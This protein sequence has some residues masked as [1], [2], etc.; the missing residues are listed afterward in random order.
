[1]PRLKPKVL[2]NFL[3]KLSMGDIIDKLTILIRKVYF[4]EEDAI[5]E[6]NYLIEHLDSMKIDKFVQRPGKFIVTI[7]RLA[8]IN[9]EVWNLENEFRKGGNGMS[10]IQAGRMAKSV[11]MLNAKRVKYKN[12]INRITGLGFREF[13][14]KHSS[15]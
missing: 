14:V 11:R 8:Q 9:F 2:P 10:D 12:E 6:L 15:S 1:M 3:P 4:G 13:K 5:E 7:I